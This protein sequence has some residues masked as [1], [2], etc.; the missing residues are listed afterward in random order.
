M[1]QFF[2]KFGPFRV[3]ERFANVAEPIRFSQ[4]MDYRAILDNALVSGSIE[5]IYR[6]YKGDQQ[7]A[8]F[9]KNLYVWQPLNVELSVAQPTSGRIVC[10]DVEDSLRISVVLDKKGGFQWR[11]C[12][13]KDCGKLFKLISKRS[14]LYCSADCAHLQSVRSYNKRKQDAELKKKQKTKS[15]KR[16]KA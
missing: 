2:Q 15:M 5:N 9:I 14:K 16:K 7:I 1:L 13:R 12:V 10:K 3:K 11:R 4:L 6:K 8:E